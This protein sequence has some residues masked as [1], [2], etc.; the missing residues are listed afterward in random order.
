MAYVA[1]LYMERDYRQLIK[2]IKFKECGTQTLKMDVKECEIQFSE[3]D[4]NEDEELD[5]HDSTDTRS[6]ITSLFE[7]E[8][9]EESLSRS[10]TPTPNDPFDDNKSIISSTSSR[11]R[12][13]LVEVPEIEK[14]PVSHTLQEVQTIDQH[15][16]SN[17]N[18]QDSSPYEKRPLLTSSP[19]ESEDEEHPPPLPQKS[20]K[21][22]ISKP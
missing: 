19:V 12:R 15:H 20:S 9:A 18:H 3:E 13:E 5:W 21:R 17:K 14:L 10:I 2:P 7:N 11:V 22:R 16:L 1:Y 6:D 4:F 8:F